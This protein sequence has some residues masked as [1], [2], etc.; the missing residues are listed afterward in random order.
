V[1]GLGLG[2]I[3]ADGPAV[4]AAGSMG[5]WGQARDGELGMGLKTTCSARLDFV[6]M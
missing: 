1:T 5:D 4:R 2:G 6:H 3:G